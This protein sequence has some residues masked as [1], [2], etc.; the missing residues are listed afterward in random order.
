MNWE[1]KIDLLKKKYPAGT[2]SVPHVDRKEI[3][4][5]IETKFISR[6][7]DYYHSNDFNARFCNWWAH[8]KSPLD[9]AV[10]FDYQALLHFILDPDEF[11][12]IACEFPG[13]ILIYKAK[14]GA[15]LYLIA[16]G[17]TWSNTF[18]I[19]HPKYEYLVSLRLEEARTR[20]RTAGSKAFEEKLK[21]A[22]TPR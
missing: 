20:I 3:L 1:E 8:I 15:I 7:E 13:S 4:W 6:P 5:N 14:L 2:F 19:V 16:N 9:L 22:I 11:F 18:H 10:D 17:Q 12:W 21:R